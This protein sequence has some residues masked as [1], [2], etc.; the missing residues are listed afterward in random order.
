MYVYRDIKKEKRKKKN[1]YHLLLSYQR[2]HY[3][4][5]AESNK[6]RAMMN[7]AIFIYPQSGRHRET[8]VEFYIKSS[9]TL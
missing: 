2:G 6:D 4:T 3:K 7:A 1:K 8:S 5:A 9:R